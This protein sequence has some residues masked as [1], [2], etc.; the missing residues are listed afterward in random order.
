MQPALG[1]GCPCG[2][3]KMNLERVPNEEKLNLCRKYYL[4]GFALLPFLWLVNVL[5]FFREAFLAPAY[6]QQLQ[7]KSCEWEERG[8]PGRES[9]E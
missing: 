6:T 9:L 3:A 5:W 2:S 4:G 7:I 8:E 1:C